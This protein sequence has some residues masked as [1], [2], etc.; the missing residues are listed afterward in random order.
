MK[1]LNEE[2]MKE[3]SAGGLSLAGIF[4]LVAAGISFIGGFLDGFTR[5]YKCR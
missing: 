4:A 5:P 2:K 1:Q 3:V